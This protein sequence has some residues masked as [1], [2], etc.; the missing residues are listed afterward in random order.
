M[1]RYCKSY[2]DDKKWKMLKS[3]RKQDFNSIIY[4]PIRMDPNFSVAK[5]TLESQMSV[6]LSSIAK[7]TDLTV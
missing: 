5:A 4:K 1:E 7:M 2:Q 6:C 3:C